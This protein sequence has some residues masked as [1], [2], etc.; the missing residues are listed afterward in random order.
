[1]S[2]KYTTGEAAEFLEL[3]GARVRKLIADGLLKAEKVG[4]YSVIDE[5]ELKRFKKLKRSP[6]RPSKESTAAN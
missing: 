6:G 1:M 3:S 2:K 5:V 4:V